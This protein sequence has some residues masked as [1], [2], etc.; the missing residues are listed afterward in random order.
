[1]VFEENAMNPISP[2]VSLG[3]GDALVVTDMQND[4]LSGGSLA[5]PGGDAVVAAA[6]PCPAATPWWSPRRPGSIATPTPPWA[7][8]CTRP[9]RAGPRPTARWSER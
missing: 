2:P 5:V 6:W 4:F 9:A 1:M 7:S 8:A 3:Q